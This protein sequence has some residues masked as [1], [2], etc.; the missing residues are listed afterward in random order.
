MSRLNT[1]S[2]NTVPTWSLPFGALSNGQHERAHCTHLRL[3]QCH[4]ALP[5]QE[6]C[7]LALALQSRRQFDNFGGD[8]AM[9]HMAGPG[10]YATCASPKE[11]Q[12]VL[13]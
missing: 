7:S 1:I 9:S 11:A 4:M 6:R 12:R 8:V 5:V 10:A 2:L 13:D 3:T